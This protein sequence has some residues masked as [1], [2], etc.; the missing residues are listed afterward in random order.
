MQLVNLTN[1]SKPYLDYKDVVLIRT[2]EDFKAFIEFYKGDA[3]KVV[4]QVLKSG[5]PKDRWDHLYFKSPAGIAFMAAVAK[6]NIAGGA[7]LLLMDELG[8][9]T[10]HSK[11]N[12]ILRG[13]TLVQQQIGSYFGIED[14]SEWDIKVLS[15]DYDFGLTKTHKIPMGTKYINLE[16]DPELEQHTLDFMKENDPNFS[17][18]LNLRNY[19]KDDLVKVFKTFVQRGGESLYLYTTGLDVPQIKEYLEAAVEAGVKAAKF[20]FNAGDQGFIPIL[21]R[22][23]EMK[24]DYDFL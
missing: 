9:E 4:T 16:N 11:L 14:E 23:T 24:I 12:I 15:E 8:D 6:C 20:E 10:L 3:K 17:Y 19:S 2:A 21:E 7:P 1:K 13:H 18:V 5:V 22:C